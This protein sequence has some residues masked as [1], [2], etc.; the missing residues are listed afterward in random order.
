MI[1]ISRFGLE[2]YLS[3]LARP[4]QDNAF[5]LEKLTNGKVKSVDWASEDARDLV[6]GWDAPNW[7]LAPLES[8]PD[9]ALDAV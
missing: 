4:N 1:G 8:T 5:K 7:E 6:S 9:Q 3:G 2:R